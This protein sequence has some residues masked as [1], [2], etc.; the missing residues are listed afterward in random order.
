[1]R[2]L[3]HSNYKNESYVPYVTSSVVQRGRGCA[4]VREG[5]SIS[6]SDN[7]PRVPCSAQ[8]VSGFRLIC[9]QGR[10]L[11]VSSINI[12][13][14]VVLT[15]GPFVFSGNLGVYQ[16]LTLSHTNLSIQGSVDILPLSSV[17][18]DETSSLSMTGNLSLSAGGIV[19]LS[20]TSSGESPLKVSG[21]VNFDG[22]NVEV[23][24]PS[25]SPGDTI[26]VLESS[27]WTDA[28]IASLN[29]AVTTTHGNSCQ[30]YI[31]TIS[32]NG[33]LLTVQLLDISTC[34]PAHSLSTPN[35]L[36]SAAST[37]LIYYASW[38]LF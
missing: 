34:A 25:V 33:L 20:G 28:T 7:P 9:T 36:Q 8:Y 35:S 6:N 19:R 37:A 18:I 1:M 26:S 21:C 29:V 10:W 32:N 23:R 17:S 15:D 16:T 31:P 5:R 14:P 2:V 13:S 4:M 11:S 38:C 22:G 30:E 3:F 12:T 24:V 27:C